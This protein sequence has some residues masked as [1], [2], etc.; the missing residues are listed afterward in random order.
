MDKIRQ[1]FIEDVVK[2]FI[3]TYPQEH[4]A[5]VKWIEEKRKTNLNAFGA[6]EKM[7]MRF[8]LK[9][10]ARLFTFLDGSLKGD[11]GLRFLDDKEESDWFCRNFPFYRIG[12]KF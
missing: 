6:D 2:R 5:V 11:A 4:N 1:N 7:E 10:P 12:T 3:A 9:I 8:L